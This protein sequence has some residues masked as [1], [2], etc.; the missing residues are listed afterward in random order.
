MESSHDMMIERLSAIFVSCC[1]IQN[2]W[3]KVVYSTSAPVAL[4]AM[5]ILLLPVD[6]HMT[7]FTWR[8]L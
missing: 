7:N 4:I 5:E 6:F 3:V 1:I 8:S 2:P